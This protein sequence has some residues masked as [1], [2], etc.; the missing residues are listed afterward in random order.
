[1]S[2]A[3]NNRA[4]L[5]RCCFVLSG[6]GEYPR[7]I[8]GL[9]YTVFVH[10]RLVF[11]TRSCSCEFYIT[12]DY[13]CLTKNQNTP[14]RQRRVLV[15]CCFVLSSD[16]EYPCSIH[17]LFYTVFVQ[18]RLVFLTR[19]C[20]CE[21][22]I[23]LD[24]YWYCLRKI[25][26]HLDLLSI[27]QSRGKNVKCCVLFFFFFFGSHLKPMDLIITILP[28]VTKDLPISPRFAPYNFFIALVARVV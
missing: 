10:S 24:Y 16:G 3:P 27:P 6:D 9:F 4:R 19:S 13:Y 23:T 18:S 21:F 1:M 26:T 5:T 8:H 20:S 12:L 11:L 17:G 25:R 22:Y 7:S 15:R 2:A 14:R 28:V